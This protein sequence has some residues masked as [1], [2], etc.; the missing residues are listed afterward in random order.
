MKTQ[1]KAAIVLCLLVLTFFNLHGISKP[2]ITEI[3]LQHE[4]LPTTPSKEFGNTLKVYYNG[5]TADNTLYVRNKDTRAIQAQVGYDGVFTFGLRPQG[6]EYEIMKN[7]CPPKA[8]CLPEYEVLKTIKLSA[9]E[10][11]SISL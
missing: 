5:Y 11:K 4:T 10:D 3:P 6:G 2:I 7:N 1:K 9:G 8:D